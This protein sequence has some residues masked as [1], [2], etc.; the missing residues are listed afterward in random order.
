MQICGWKKDILQQN[1]QY[2]KI[3][4]FHPEFWELDS[5]EQV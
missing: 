2:I 4:I 5:W 3:G 1:L